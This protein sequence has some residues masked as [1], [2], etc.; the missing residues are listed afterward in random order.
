MN[1]PP[2]IRG[3]KIAW[4]VFCVTAAVLL[5]ALWLLSYFWVI[6]VTKTDHTS[7]WKAISS[8]C[9]RIIVCHFPAESIDYAA[10][11]NRAP[12][13]ELT[14]KKLT[15]DYELPDDTFGFFLDRSGGGFLLLVPYWFLLL[16]AALGPL[17]L[18]GPR[19]SLRTLLIVTTLVA[20]GL[21]LVAWLR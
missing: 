19:F 17:P 7:G 14:N 13:W 11:S 4:A 1:R 6:G 10:G 16:L 5:L 12:V 18:A 3:I 21:G 20:I 2:L 9:G 8:I 15:P